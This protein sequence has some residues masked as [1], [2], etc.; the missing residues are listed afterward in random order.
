MII[1]SVGTI[2]LFQKLRARP[3]WNLRQFCYPTLEGKP[4]PM[5]EEY[6]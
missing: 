6:H 3:C 5:V 2:F 4:E 1:N